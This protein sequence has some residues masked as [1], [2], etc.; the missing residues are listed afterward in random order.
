MAELVGDGKALAPTPRHAKWRRR[1][2]RAGRCCIFIKHLKICKCYAGF[3]TADFVNAKSY[4][5]V[6]NH[7]IRDTVTG[8]DTGGLTRAS[9]AEDPCS[10][11]RKEPQSDAQ[12]MGC[13]IAFSSLIAQEVHRQRTLVLESESTTT[14][15]E[16]LMEKLL[17]HRPAPRSDVHRKSHELG[18]W[19]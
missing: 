10:L 14:L 5:K 12:S 6:P 1:L 9:T 11:E 15:N 7:R 3:G 16:W 17:R 18:Q 2:R 19:L 8:R 13:R 4:R